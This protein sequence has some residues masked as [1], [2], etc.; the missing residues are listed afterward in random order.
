MLVLVRRVPRSRGTT[1]EG[2]IVVREAFGLCESPRSVFRRTRPRRSPSR[3]LPPGIYAPC[4]D[5]RS[6]LPRPNSVGHERHDLEI[7]LASRKKR[8]G[9]GG[10]ARSTEAPLKIHHVV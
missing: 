7:T 6:N 10:V 1:R 2:A 4:A 8:T 5:Q 9:S 3:Q